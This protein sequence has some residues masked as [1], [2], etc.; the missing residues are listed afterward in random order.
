VVSIYKR[1]GIKW[2]CVRNNA[3]YRKAYDDYCLQLNGLMRESVSENKIQVFK[4]GQLELFRQKYGMAW[5]VNYQISYFELE[6]AIRGKRITTILEEE[7][8]NLLKDK[9]LF[10]EYS[11]SKM[12]INVLPP[13]KYRATVFRNLQA[14]LRNSLKI[15]RSFFHLQS[16]PKN[17]IIGSS[18]VEATDRG[19]LMSF[20]I[21]THYHTLTQITGDI[22]N[23]LKCLRERFKEKRAQLDADEDC[24]KIYNNKQAGRSWREIMENQKGNSGEDHDR[25]RQLKRQYAKAKRLISNILTK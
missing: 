12:D 6:I 5:P 25:L 13:Q 16:S 19:N 8:K 2:E 11:I 10:G 3:E 7:R 22:K 21:E 17:L 18:I 23:L 24:L 9:K 20:T 15:E 4:N 14:I 1:L